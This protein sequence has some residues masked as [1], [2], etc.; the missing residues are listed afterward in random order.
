MSMLSKVFYTFAI[1]HRATAETDISVFFGN[2]SLP[3]SPFCQQLLLNQF[4]PWKL[5]TM[6]VFDTNTISTETGDYKNDTAQQQQ[7]QISTE[8]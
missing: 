1:P 2:Y 3:A 5:I 8:T 4:D 7:R 6:R